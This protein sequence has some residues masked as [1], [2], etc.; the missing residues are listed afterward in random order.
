MD[1]MFVI[2]QF[3][4][5]AEMLRVS[6]ASLKNSL[7]SADLS[8]HLWL[9]GAVVIYICFGVRLAGFHCVHLAFL[10]FCQ[11]TGNEGH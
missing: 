5:S 2:I 7:Y 1:E 10:F 6:G 8:A 11:K 4:S 9:S 3:H